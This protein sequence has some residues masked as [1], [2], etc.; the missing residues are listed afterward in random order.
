MS[1]R[2][3][4]L[5]NRGFTL[6]ELMVVVAIVGVLAAIAIPQYQTYVFKSQV[7]R[8]IG[9]SGAIKAAVEL[10]LLVG[11][12]DVGNPATA[13]NCDPQATGSNLQATAGN[14]APTIAATWSAP[15]TGVPQVSLSATTASK[16]V[17]T[18]GNLAGAP[19]QGATAGTITWERD[20]NG[21]WSCKAANVEPKYVSTACPL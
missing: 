19:L 18:F 1:M 9:E 17:A 11:K 5:E 12:F 10:C 2:R 6:I 4:N 15:G 8:V 14:A 20:L 7:Q 3:T 13:G 16:I 21:T